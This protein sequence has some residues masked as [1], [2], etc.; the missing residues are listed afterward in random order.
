MNPHQKN[1]VDVK[2]LSPEEQRLF[3]LYG[4]L[5][6][7]SDHFAKHLKDRKYFDSGD[8]AMSK[9]GKGDGVDAG[10]VGSQHPVPEN[11]PHL[12]SP[13]GSSNGPKHVHASIPGI[14]AGSPIKESSFLKSETN[15]DEAQQEN[16]E[17]ADKPKDPAAAPPAP[18]GE[19]IPIR[20]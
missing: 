18:V 4:K 3:R 6:S 14:Q 9:A 8:Y 15:A 7:R 20:R 19:S 1:K 13:N 16:G 11:I 5:P 17:D 12:S 2:S 10:A